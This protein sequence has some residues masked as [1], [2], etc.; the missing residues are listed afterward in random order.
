[1]NSSRKRIAICWSGQL[2]TG[3]RALPYLMNFFKE[4]N[5]DHFYHSWTKSNI[6]HEYE[7]SEEEWKEINDI[8]NPVDSFVETNWKHKGTFG[9]MMYSIQQANWLKRKYEIENNFRYDIVIKARFDLLIPVHKV[10]RYHDVVDRSI[11]YS[12]GNNG[13][14]V[15]D[16]A[17]HGLS[18]LIFWGNSHAMD[19]VCDT[20]RYYNNKLI[21]KQTH[22][23]TGGN[24]DPEDCMLSP[25]TIV[26]QLGQRYNLRMIQIQ[27]LLGETLWRNSVED[28][29]PVLDW[30][31]IRRAY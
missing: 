5:A 21:P 28:L 7:H 16:F 1:M 9:N 15:T 8:I 11:Y 22:C 27:P 12:L 13:L 17:T 4:T 18:D 6:P 25:G 30:E 19:I 26:Y 31:K 3:K 20:Y 23:L 2:R 10:W 24:V 14:G 29:D